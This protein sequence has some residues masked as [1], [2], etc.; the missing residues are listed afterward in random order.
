M[1]RSDH[2][3]PISRRIW[4]V[5][6]IEC[7]T[8]KD[9]LA[10]SRHRYRPADVR[11]TELT[12]ANSTLLYE[13]KR[14]AV[15]G[16]LGACSWLLWDKE[17]QI[18]SPCDTKTVY[19]MPSVRHVATDASWSTTVS[20]FCLPSAGVRGRSWV[21]SHGNRGETNSHLASRMGLDLGPND[22]RRSLL[23]SVASIL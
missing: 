8:M 18:G 4:S 10:M 15:G 13:G 2:T 21:P 5:S 12:I 20:A 3:C 22:E 17:T 16:C 6:S 9:E 19:G 11:S 7:S 1:I 23:K 14:R